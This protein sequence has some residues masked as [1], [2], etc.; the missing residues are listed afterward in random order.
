MDGRPRIG[1][2]GPRGRPGPGKTNH[3]PILDR[4]GEPAGDRIPGDAR[5]PTFDERQPTEG[6]PRPTPSRFVD[7][8]NTIKCIRLTRPALLLVAPLVMTACGSGGVAKAPAEGTV[9]YG[10]RPLARGYVQFSPEA[11]ATEAN[12]AATGSIEAGT[13]A[14]G[15][16]VDGDGVVPGS[17]RSRSSPMRKS[18]SRMVRPR[19]GRSSPIATP[20]PI[21]RASSW[22]YR[23]GGI[24]PS[25]STWWTARTVPLASPRGRVVS[26]R[27][28]PAEPTGG[29]SHAATNECDG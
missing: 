11:G 18:G 12:P 3:E 21:L 27:A 26:P 9:T 25:S 7:D 16:L 13:F 22:R 8:M 4:L 29:R 28:G 14:L 1:G 23:G 19:P 20:T 6:R 2:R 17:T 24:V 15:T 5:A 10:G